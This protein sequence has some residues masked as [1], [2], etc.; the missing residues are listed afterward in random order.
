ME[1][2]VIKNS[3]LALNPIQVNAEYKE[4]W[5]EHCSDFLLLTKGGEVLR[6][7]LYRIGGLNNPNLEKDRYF[8]LLKHS[9]AFYADDITTDKKRKPHLQSTW[10]ILDSMGNEKVVFPTFTHPRII[11]NS[12]VYTCDNKYIN[13]ET[14]EVYAD[15]AAVGIESSEFIFIKNRFDKDESRRGVLKV[16]KL[17]GKWELFK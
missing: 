10:C 7:T 17:T 9:E 8:M 4:K 13:I 15:Y 3:D 11:K 12:V 16:D 5:N 14:G 1:I 6:N 2:A